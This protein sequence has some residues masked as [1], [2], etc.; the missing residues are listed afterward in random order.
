LHAA[1]SI[2]GSESQSLVLSA[3][4]QPGLRSETLV[5]DPQTLACDPPTLDL[6]YDPQTLKSKPWYLNLHSGSWPVH[7]DIHVT[8]TEFTSN[9]LGQMGGLTRL[10]VAQ[11]AS[12]SAYPEARQL[13]QLKALS[14]GFNTRSETAPRPLIGPAQPL[15]SIIL[16]ALKGSVPL[17]QVSEPVPCVVWQRGR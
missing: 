9:G 3:N 17:G 8:G 12:A 15:T 14:I 6:V 5:C 1:R 16:H 2:L 4:S 11:M 7:R 10:A 13:L